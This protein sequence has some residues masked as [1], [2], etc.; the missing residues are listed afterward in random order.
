METPAVTKSQESETDLEILIQS[1]PKEKYWLRHG[2]DLHQIQ[3]FWIPSFAIRGIIKFRNQFLARDTDVILASFPKS[4]TTW[5]KALTYSIVNRSYDSSDNPLTRFSPHD[6]VHN[7]ENFIFKSENYPDLESLPNPR[8]FAT[9]SP[10]Q[11]LP[12]SIKNSKCKVVY[13][14]RNLLDQFVSRWH[15]KD[16]VKSETPQ[17]PISEAFEMFYQGIDGYGPSWAHLLGYW[18]AGMENPQ[19]VLFLKYEDLKENPNF[20]V[21]K[22]AEFVGFPFSEEEEREG[23]VERIVKFC[24]FE[25]LKNL[26]VN[27][28]GKRQIGPLKNSAYFR[29]G[30]VGD[31]AN[32]LT[33]SMVE[34]GMKLMEDKFSGSGLSFK[35]SLPEAEES[36]M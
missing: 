19:K 13:V 34:R 30:K 32:C 27:K 5:L 2:L 1:L 29:K 17:F 16:S 20:Y 25:N 7:F 14:C 35:L 9:H 33:P 28:N 4:G 26:E 10:Y 24:S 6:L 23:V 22:L 36:V 31:W 15:F 3:G 12:E 18:N 11:L 21:K 8:I